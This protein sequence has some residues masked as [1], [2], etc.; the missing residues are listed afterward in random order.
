MRITAEQE[1]ILNRVTCARLSANPANRDKIQTFTGRRGLAL[2]QYLKLKGWELD[3]N[4]ENAFYL[5]KNPQ[6][7]PCVFFALKCGALYTP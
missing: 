3:E 4:G 1:N 5:I 7:E 6:G 2:V